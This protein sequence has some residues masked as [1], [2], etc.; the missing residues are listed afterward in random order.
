ML[1]IF[2]VILA[3]WSPTIQLPTLLLFSCCDA[4]VVIIFNDCPLCILF[5]FYL[6]CCIVVL[7]A[8]MSGDKGNVS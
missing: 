7:F 5:S 6:Y 2:I 1:I 8:A 4:S 3:M